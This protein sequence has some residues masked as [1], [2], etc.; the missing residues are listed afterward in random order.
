MFAM[1]YA[2]ALRHEQVE[3][4]RQ[5]VAEVGPTFDG[6]PGLI[7]KAFLLATDEPC[8]SLYYLWADLAAMEAFL[9][10]PRFAAVAQTYGRPRVT[11]YLTPSSRLPFAAGERLAI[12]PTID[13][14]A[15]G[16]MLT[17]PADGKRIGLRSD[18]AGAFE[19]LYVAGPNGGSTS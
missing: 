4:V 14:A 19:V 18:D 10:G 13:G 7:A 8:Y 2:I 6:L 11:L 17:D 15:A 16:V 12:G 5:R 1:H 3:A 9:D